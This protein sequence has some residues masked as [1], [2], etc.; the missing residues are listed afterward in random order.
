MKRKLIAML[1][2]LTLLCSVM[3][4]A[5]AATTFSDVPQNKWYSEGVFWCA[6]K[7][8]VSGY[9]DGTFKPGKDIT[10][11]EL[12]VIMNKML[13]LKE[14]ST[15]T[16]KDVEKGR[17][18]TI[19]VLNCVKAGVIK[20]YGNGYFGPNDKVTREQAAVIL[21]N[22]LKVHP[23]PAEGF[24]N[25]EESISGWAK[26][27]VTMMR[28]KG[29]VEGVGNN[30]FA[31]K[32]KVTRGQ[33]CTMLNTARKDNVASPDTATTGTAVEKLP[34]DELHMAFSSGVGGWGTQLILYEDGSFEG[35]YSDTDMGDS[36][37][38]YDA[39]IYNSSFEGKFKNIR[40]VSD[41]QYIM[42]LDSIEYLNEVGSS[43]IEGSARYV[44]TDAY[45]LRE[46][47]SFTLLLKGANI[48]VLP[49]NAQ[50]WAK[51]GAVNHVVED[52]GVLSA[53]VFYTDG[54]PGPFVE[55]MYGKG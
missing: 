49:K 32:E 44:N 26:G 55:M 40:K 35:I 13:G 10:R 53:A 8:L 28:N 3:P 45:G 20:G 31:P 43:E 5:F 11:G 1:V 27:Y 54:A 2:V 22:A 25:D 16:F 23:S 4:A 38:G 47:D 24:F 19:P 14:A 9:P 6:E 39:T 18:Y 50:D 21:A 52:D 48:S 42:D 7:G 15:E 12:A 36:G 41:S 46:G 51:A 33:I 17:Y 37:D 30:L 29:L 34:V